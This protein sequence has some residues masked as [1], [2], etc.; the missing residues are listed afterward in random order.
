MVALFYFV[1]KWYRLFI[2]NYV[3]KKRLDNYSAR[4]HLEKW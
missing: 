4:K 2:I 1:Y 3:M